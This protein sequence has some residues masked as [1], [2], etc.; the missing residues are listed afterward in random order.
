MAEKM[1]FPSSCATDCVAVSVGNETFFFAKINQK[2]PRLP[3]QP[4]LH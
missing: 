2:G 3:T 4:V 1:H